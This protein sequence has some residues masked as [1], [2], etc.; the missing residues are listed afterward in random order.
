MRA[1]SSRCVRVAA[2]APCALLCV[3]LRSSLFGERRRRQT[4]LV[5]PR[6]KQLVDSDA[7]RGDDFVGYR[8]CFLRSFV[9]VLIG[10]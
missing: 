5:M 6:A 8:S 10:H 4:L 1:S 2:P 7:S 9:G 3:V